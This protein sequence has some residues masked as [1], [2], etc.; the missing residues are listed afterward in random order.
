[1]TKPGKVPSIPCTCGRLF[2]TKSG[3]TRHMLTCSEVPERVKEALRPKF[4]AMRR[5]GNRNRVA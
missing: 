1:M 2:T 3:R 5:E 4:P